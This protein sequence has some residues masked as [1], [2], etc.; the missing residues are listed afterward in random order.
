[1]SIEFRFPDVGEGLAE[2]EIVRWLIPEGGPVRE[3]QAI[4]EVETDKSLVE[5]TSP[6]TG[7]L[8]VHGAPEGTVIAVGAV[9]AT[10]ESGAAAAAPDAH[11]SDPGESASAPAA[12]AVPSASAPAAPAVPAPAV[13]ARGGQRPKASPSTRGL[14]RSLGVDLSLVVGTGTG[15]RI[16]DQDVRAAS[17]GAAATASA[18]ATASATAAAPTAPAAPSAP[19]APLPRIEPPVG[20][21]QRI[22]MRGVR[23]AIARNMLQSWTTVPHVDSVHEVDLSEMQRLR[24]QLKERGRDVPMT[25]FLV[26]AAAIALREFPVLNAS[27][28]GEKEEM[29]LHHRVNIGVAVDAP[30]GLIVPVIDDADLKDVVR[31]GEELRELAAQTRDRSVPTERLRGGTFTV[32]NYGPLG[33]WFGTSL[34]KPPEVGI[35]SIGPARDQVVPRDGQIVIRPIAA[36][37]LAADHRVADGREI[38]GFCVSVRRLMEAPI[39]LLLEG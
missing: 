36:M 29:V 34:V 4:V 14:A 2:A 39:N 15:G 6:V 8:T 12:P 30:D 10:F 26:R 38:I 21:D 28:D 19:P 13:P 37:V 32:N 23:R 25:A 9:L 16:L 31:I 33:G 11:A 35:L 27:V 24:A 5:I 3:D 1:M 17:T 20:E 7:V 18:P 22:P